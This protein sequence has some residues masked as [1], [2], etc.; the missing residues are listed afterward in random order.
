[1]V[2]CKS[3]VKERWGQILKEAERIP[4]KYL[5]TLDEALTDDGVARMLSSQLTVFLPKPIIER[6]YAASPIRNR[7]ETVSALINSLQAA[8][9]QAA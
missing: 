4:G 6:A 7:V 9:R 3:R 8:R 5:L 1:M 2:A